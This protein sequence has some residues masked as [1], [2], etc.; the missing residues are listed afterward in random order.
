MMREVIYR[1]RYKRN[2]RE[3]CQKRRDKEFER[4]NKEIYIYIG[5]YNKT[6]KIEKRTRRRQLI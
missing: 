1:Q 2:K 5:I 4:P 3:K 6:R